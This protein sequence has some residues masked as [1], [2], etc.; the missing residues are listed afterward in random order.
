MSETPTLPEL[1][2]DVTEKAQRETRRAESA[3][4]ALRE[5]DIVLAA[6]ERYDNQMEVG[7]CDP[8]LPNGLRRNI[9]AIRRRIGDYL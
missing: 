9:E 2:A 8:P 5:A 6:V 1:L 3:I 4:N 7:A